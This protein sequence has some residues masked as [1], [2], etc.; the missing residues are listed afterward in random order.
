MITES[1]CS[2]LSFTNIAA[3]SVNMNEAQKG[4]SKKRQYRN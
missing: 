1:I 2:H 4:K 3:M